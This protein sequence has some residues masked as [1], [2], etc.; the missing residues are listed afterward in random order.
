MILSRGECV[1]Y[2]IFRGILF[3]SMVLNAK[4]NLFGI[5]K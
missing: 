5:L 4:H 1:S 2:I 3:I